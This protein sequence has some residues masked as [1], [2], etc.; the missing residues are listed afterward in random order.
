M[1]Q[2]REATMTCISFEVFPP[3]SVDASFDL[4]RTGQML[5]PLEPAFFSVTCGAGSGTATHA[6]TRDASKAIARRFGA[7]VMAH[8]TM[9]GQSRAEVLSAAEALHAA[10]IRD[11]LALRGDAAAGQ[12]WRA[13]QDGFASSVDMVAALAK[14]GQFKI[15]V[16][17]YPEAHP[18]SASAAQNIDWLKVKLDAGATSA[19]TQ[20]FFEP[21][22]FL[23]FR[24]ACA[25]AGLTAPLIPG[26]MPITNWDQAARFAARVGC[27]PPLE[28]ARGFAAATRDG[29]T[30]LM[31][32][33]HACEMAEV[34]IAEG[35]EHLHFYTLNRP[36][37]TRDICAAL[38]LGEVG[39]RD[40]A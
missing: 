6:L 39:L 1:E 23:R 27:T 26:L 33:A 13:H 12:D 32:L 10:G 2:A 9:V 22:T 8:L 21:E 19:I 20:F 31:A 7:P 3:R 35:V 38:S 34:L 28:L 18:D 11:I 16:A 14:T 15:R 5:A 17:A 36:E 30:R 4:W 37:L 40:V 24:D 29:R 25:A